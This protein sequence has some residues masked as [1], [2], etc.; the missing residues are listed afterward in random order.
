[1]TT[2]QRPPCPDLTCFTDVG[3]FFGIPCAAASAL[4]A[5]IVIRCPVRRITC[6]VRSYLLI[7][8]HQPDQLPESHVHI[9]RLPSRALDEWRRQSFG[10]IST[11]QLAHT[12]MP[13]EITLASLSNF[14]ADNWP[15]DIPCLTRLRMARSPCPSSLRYLDGKLLLPQMIVGLS[16]NTPARIPSR[17]GTTG[18]AWHC[19]HSVRFRMFDDANLYSSGR[20]VSAW[21]RKQ[22]GHTLPCG[23]EDIELHCLPVN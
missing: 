16:S 18:P 19:N 14:H 23:V 21:S 17:S 13:F 11:L 20:I 1:M 10:Q 4:E 3:G 2:Q 8:P 15:L 5:L 6:T 9:D 22:K 7:P 12:S